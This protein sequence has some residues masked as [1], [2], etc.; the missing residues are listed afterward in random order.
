MHHASYSLEC[1]KGQKAGALESLHCRLCEYFYSCLLIKTS[2]CGRIWPTTWLQYKNHMI[3]C[4]GGDWEPPPTSIYRKLATVPKI[5]NN[6]TGL[7]HF[8]NI[9]GR[10]VYFIG[11]WLFG[12]GVCDLSFCVLNISL[13]KYKMLI[14][15][16]NLKSCGLLLHVTHGEIKAQKDCYILKVNSSS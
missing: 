9:S 15:S 4:G 13:W 11:L 5:R 8:G 1:S 7:S 2:K 10:T 3:N 14:L 12:K 6:H 16:G